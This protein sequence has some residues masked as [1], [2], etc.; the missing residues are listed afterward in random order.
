MIMVLL[1]KKDF[2]NKDDMNENLKIV[3]ENTTGSQF[4]KIIYLYIFYVNLRQKIN[5]PLGTE[6][7][8]RKEITQR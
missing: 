5:D 2:Y 7:Q 4:K 6:G 1:K 8:K 3:E